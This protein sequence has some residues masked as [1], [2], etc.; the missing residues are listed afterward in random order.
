MID[1]MWVDNLIKVLDYENRLYSQLFSLAESKSEIIINGEIDS[2]QAT[3]LDE[4]RL[5][6]DLNKLTEAREHIVEQIGKKTGKAV[7]DVIVSD[8]IS[9][10]PEEHAK[11]LS[12]VKDKLKDTIDKLRARNA[13][14]RKLLKNALDYVDFSLT[15]LTESI[16]QTAQYG[17]KGYEPGNKGRVILDIKS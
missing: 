17:R 16:P 7:K 15:L 3:I 13:L 12:A 8:I 2:L 6:A 1:L 14:N 11:K 4:Q 10:L 5:T 9:E